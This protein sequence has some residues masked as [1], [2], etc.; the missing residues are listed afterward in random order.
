MR[1]N[2]VDERF[3]T[4]DASPREKFDAWVATVPHTLRNP[5]YHWSHLELA[6]TFGIFDI[7]DKNSADKI[8]REANAKLPG[9]RVHDLLAANKV[10]VICTTDDP[11]E[12]LED[13]KKI[14]KLGL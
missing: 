14:A 3:C 7:I 10:A 11:A 2:G 13:H 5:L 6:R 4:G 9:L 1:A 12:S 8:W